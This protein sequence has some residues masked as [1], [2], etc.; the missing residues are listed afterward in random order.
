M[1]N[2]Q[3]TFPNGSVSVCFDSES[4]AAQIRTSTPNLN[5]T[6]T[7]TDRH[8]A[9][10]HESETVSMLRSMGMAPIV[11]QIEPG[12]A[13]KGLAEVSRLFETM[14][15]TG[16][17]R[18][19]LIIALGG[20]VVNDLTG[21]VAAT[22]MRGIKWLAIPTTVEAMVDACV[23]GKTAINLPAGKNLVGAFHHPAAI[24]INPAYLATLP[25]RDVRAGL[26]ESIKH[27][28]LFDE[29][30]LVEHERNA[31]AILNLDPGILQGLIARN[32]QLKAEIV[33]RDPLEQTGERML[34]NFG[35][36]IGHALEAACGFALRH[37]ECVALG[38]LAECRLSASRGMLDA[39]VV[40]RLQSVL[41]Q[42]GLPTRMEQTV[43]MAAILTYLRQDKKARDGSLRFVLL[44]GVGQPEVVRDVQEVE[45]RQ[46]VESI[47]C[48]TR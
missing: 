30:F 21:F 28:L 2:Q 36:T 19:G 14:A 6:I 23:G 7:V 10:F 46:A 32:I 37:G 42:F 22:W 3:I 5:S 44:R 16:I 11:H 35:H 40:Q 9:G 41:T 13:S 8:V 1:R 24:Y 43:D 45:I 39:R 17:G 47:L 12:E 15:S 25:L 4:L 20:G 29:A 38:M 31:E 26:A 48:P 18:D 27:A 33:R 34:L